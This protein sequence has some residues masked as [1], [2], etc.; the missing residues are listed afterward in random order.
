MTRTWQDG[1][2]L[3]NS[4][5]TLSGGQGTVQHVVSL[6]GATEGALKILHAEGQ[7]HRERRFRIRQEA[8]AL[9]AMASGVPKLLDS[10]VDDA[11]T[12]DPLFLVMEWIPG[13]TLTR[14]AAGRPLSIDDAVLCTIEILKTLGE[15]HALPIVHRDLKPDNVILRDGKPSLPV[16]V[17]LGLAWNEA[18]VDDDQHSRGK[19]IGNRFLR[20][21][22]FAIGRDSH[23]ARSDICLATGLLFFMVTG[24][25]PRILR[26]EHGRAPHES[27]KDSIPVRCT[28]DKRW[29]KLLRVFTR[30][31]QPE[32]SLRYQTAEE[33]AA[34][35][36]DLEPTEAPGDALTPALERLR[37][38]MESEKWRKRLERQTAIGELGF[39]FDAH[40]RLILTSAKIPIQGTLAFDSST[41]IFNS[42]IGLQL[43]VRGG[44]VVCWLYHGITMSDIEVSAMFGVQGGNVP[45]A[46]YYRGS[47]VDLAGL[48]EAMWA[49]SGRIVAVTIDEYRR[50]QSR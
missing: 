16:I 36:S 39:R 31:F 40:L 41:T 25:F 44:G 15:M 46:E 11:D 7:L 23:H 1:W 37:D 32:L 47:I 27:L 29:P 43:P 22:E 48:E 50:L 20:L 2:Q 45:S 17:D 6:D 21:P 8:N 13:D 10:N 12:D 28:S 18:R 19:E 42:N 14:A 4:T 5:A 3:V 49:N 24:L 33:L 35:I 30:G 9:S 34:A 26:D 38:D